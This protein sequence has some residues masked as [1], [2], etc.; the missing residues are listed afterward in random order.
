MRTIIELV[1]F[2]SDSQKQKTM[3]KTFFLNCKILNLRMV[4]RCVH[5]SIRSKLNDEY[6][7]SLIRR[8]SVRRVR[9]TRI[10]TQQTNCH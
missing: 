10:S 7:T 4:K 9:E 8:G 3:L 2:R 6:S 5:I 1:Y